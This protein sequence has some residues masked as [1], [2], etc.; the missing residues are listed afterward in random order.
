MIRP[1]I[2]FLLLGGLCFTIVQGAQLHEAADG[3][4]TLA[5]ESISISASRIDQLRAD[6]LERTG[7]Q[8]STRE[9]AA[10]IDHAIDEEILFREALK[11]GVHE[12]DPVVRRRLAQNMRFLGSTQGKPALDLD[13]DR[14]FRNAME[15]GMVRSDVVT[16]RRLIQRMES[17]LSTT[18]PAPAA[19]EVRAYVQR[20]PAAFSSSPKFRLS[21]IFL[22]E[23]RTDSPVADALRSALSRGEQATGATIHARLFSERQ[24]IEAFGQ[25]LA[26]ELMALSPGRWEG[27]FPART[28]I[29]LARVDEAIPAR[30]HPFELIEA[31]ARQALLRERRR[32]AL[33][34]ALRELR[35]HYHVRVAEVP[36]TDPPPRQASLA[37]PRA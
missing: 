33:G 18:A 27:P 1:I 25:P 9:V 4:R 34:S 19:D 30:P 16:R 35:R 37:Q 28:G 6:W 24:M 8:A 22:D 21:Y 14:L 13:D 10:L 29:Y 20:H 12:V 11:L 32:R 26:A 31:R 15:L 23:R 2:H 5:V 7:S 3:Q 17:Y 36:A